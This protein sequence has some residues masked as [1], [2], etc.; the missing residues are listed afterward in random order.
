M[1]RVLF[2]SLFLSAVLLSCK[3]DKY[4]SAPQISFKSYSGNVAINAAGQQ[5]PDMKLEL[6][7]AEGDLG[8]LDKNT[9]VFVKNIT[10]PPFKEDSLRIPDLSSI[11]R[12]N[13]KVELDVRMTS[14][15]TNS[16]QPTRPY[17]DT[18]FFE[19]FVRDLAGNKSN[20]ITTTEPLFLI[21]P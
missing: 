1:R 17:T 21:T 20:V 16:G 15:L 8:Y 7:D 3:K 14:V 11:S 18:L 13:L 9:Y 5:G 6:T 12:K 2:I 19:V 4:T 10:I